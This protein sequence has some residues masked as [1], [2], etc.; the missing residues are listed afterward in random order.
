MIKLI[1]DLVSRFNEDDVPALSSQL[2]FN[3]ILSFFPFLI[4][5]MTLLGHIPLNDFDILTGLSRIL[6]S[7]VYSLTKSTVFEVINTRNSK[8]MS[9]SLLITLWSASSGFN[10]V[11]K[12]L[13]NAYNIRE[14][15]SFI[16]VRIISILCTLGMAFLIILMGVLMVFG[17]YVWNLLMITLALSYKAAVLWTIMRYSIVIATAISIFTLLYH[18]APNKKLSWLEVIPGSLFSTASLIF[19]SVAFAYYVNNFANYSI[20]YGSLGAIIVLLTWLFL[21][22]VIVIMGGELNASLTAQ[23]DTASYTVKRTKSH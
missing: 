13:N 16:R 15:R 17:K 9:F 4:F 12:G 21:V 2:A 1:L 7:S 23:T 11:I 19:V 20:A 6:P 14:S 10:A 5:L 22:S 8:L 18:I 3:L